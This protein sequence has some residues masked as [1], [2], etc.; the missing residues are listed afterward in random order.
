MP[1]DASLVLAAEGVTVR[2]PGRE[3]ILVG[4]DVAV[5][6]GTFTVIVGGNGCGKSTLLRVLARVLR[7]EAGRVT[8]GG[9]DVA[10]LGAKQF[11]RAVALLAQG[12]IAPDGITV[13]DLVARGRYPHQGLLRQWSPADAE[14]VAGAMERTET[15]ELA[16]RLVADLS[17]GQRQRV[18]IALA[19][20][21]ETG[22]LLLDEPTTYLDL[23]H[24][25]SVLDLCRDLV[26]RHGKT[27]V[28]VLHDLNHAC[29]YADRIVAMADGRIVASGP[30]AEVVTAEVVDEVFGVACRIIDDPVSGTPLVVPEL[31]RPA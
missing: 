3:P 26:D 23:A 9:G 21:Q 5:P 18:W 2:Y 28:A 31:A 15:A 8:L 29:R 14:A 7:P 11:A 24:Q 30:P 1:A 4:L 10:R 25:L 19:L 16:D 13:G 17:G 27:V 6:P 20:A 22:L 12:A